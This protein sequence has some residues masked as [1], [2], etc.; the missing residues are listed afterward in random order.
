MKIGKELKPLKS[1]QVF[2]RLTVLGKDEKRSEEAKKPYYLCQCSCGSPVKSILKQSLVDKRKSTKSCGCI[3]KEKAGFEKDRQLAL[4]KLVY[5]KIKD[6]HI[7]VLK[8]DIS[9]IISFD[10]FCNII[11]QNCYYCGTSKSSYLKDR[12]TVEVLYYNG[13]DRIDSNLG[14]RKN[15]VVPACKVCNIAKAEMT[16]E[17]FKAFLIRI[18]NHQAHKEEVYCQGLEI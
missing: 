17:E 1:G 16:Q 8:D 14:Y 13:L 5:L 7:K 2:G 15:N 9:N 18:H 3:V 11:E 6:R 10:D 4:K 12:S